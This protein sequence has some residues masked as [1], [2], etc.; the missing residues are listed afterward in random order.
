MILK[1]KSSL[2]RDHCITYLHFI[3]TILIQL[4]LKP[5]CIRTTQSFYLPKNI[6]AYKNLQV[7]KELAQPANERNL[8]IN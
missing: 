8:D 3:H 2:K 4:S 6:N 7:N 5:A 1:L